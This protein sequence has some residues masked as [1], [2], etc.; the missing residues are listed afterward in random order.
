MTTALTVSDVVAD[1]CARHTETIF[2]LMGNGNAFF[3]SNVTRRGLRYI[4]ARHEA[5]TVAMADAYHRASGKIAVATVTYGAGFTNCLTSLAE[6]AKARVPMVV[7]VGEVPT[8]GP[9]PWDIDQETVARGLGVQTLTVARDSAMAVTEQAWALAARDMRPVIVAIPYDLAAIDAGPQKP[10]MPV[11]DAAHPTA[12]EAATRDVLKVLAGAKRPLIIAGRGALLAGAGPALKDLGDRLGA[13]FATSVMARNIFSSAWDLG[14]AGGFATMAAVEIMRRADVVLVVGASLNTFQTRYGTLFDASATVI[15]VDQAEL[16]TSARVSHFVR[17]DAGEFAAALL[18]AA[19][20]RSG[21][22][23]RDDYPE[24]SDGSMSKQ[25]PEEE[26]ADDGRLN[27]RAVAQRLDSVL[28]ANRTIVQDGGHFIGWAPMYCQV[29]DPR[30]LMMVGTAFQ[31][32]GL[33]LPSAVG[34]AAARPDRLTVLVS[35]D[36]GALMGLADLDTVIRTVSSGVMV[37]FNDAAYGAEL[38]QYAV[39]GLDDTAMQI[40]EV[41]FAAL[42]KALGASGTKMRSL[43]DL[44]QL[45][46]WLD[47]GARGLFVLDVAVSQTVVAEYMQESMAPV[48]AALT[49]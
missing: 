21:R 8:T 25:R 30:A 33:G 18:A 10:V 34:A 5:G 31:T 4:S 11:D 28:P 1:S 41:D 14:I 13:L 6:A 22:G 49:N 3:T 40:D 12:G 17:A 36:G 9:R 39:R 15:Q 23:W 27:P 26:F 45:R 19:P 2:G 16:A 48:L 7:V 37:V 47:D 42:G 43:A 35:G 32:I 29:P 24:I 46:S 38:H 20:P 44:D